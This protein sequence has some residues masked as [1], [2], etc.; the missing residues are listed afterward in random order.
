MQQCYRFYYTTTRAQSLG[1]AAGIQHGCLSLA[2]FFPF[3]SIARVN[4]RRVES[5]H[6]HYS[7][8]NALIT[9]KLSLIVLER[10]C[11]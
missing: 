5:L 2:E 3:A 10:V 8:I 7:L 4:Q 9:R 1:S 6:A 11:V